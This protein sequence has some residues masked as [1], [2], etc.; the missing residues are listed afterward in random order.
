MMLLRPSP[1][2]NESL[3]GYL[4]RVADNNGLPGVRFVFDLVD[5]VTP[6]EEFGG[7]LGGGGRPLAVLCDLPGV[8]PKADG[9]CGG[10]HNSACL[11]T[12]FWNTR[13]PRFCP[14]C[15]EEFNVWQV[16]WELALVVACPRHNLVLVE[17]CSKCQQLIRWN[18]KHFLECDCG[19]SLAAI[20]AMSCTS[21]ESWISATQA[22]LL[23]PKIFEN[24]R[25]ESELGALSLNDLSLLLMYLGGYASGIST[26][27]LKIAGLYRQ[28]VAQRLVRAALSILAN[29]PENFHS[30]LYELGNFDEDAR[31]ADG[32]MKRFG[33]FYRSLYN[34]L[35]GEQFGFLREAFE[36]FLRIYWP[37]TFARRNRRLSEK[38]VHDHR[39]VPLPAAAKELHISRKTL[40]QLVT[41]GQ[42]TATTHTT[43]RGRHVVCIE[44]N[45][46][47]ELQA[48]RADWITF[49][50]ARTMLGLSKKRFRNLL[51]AGTVPALAGPKIDGSAVWR[52][53]KTLIKS[54]DRKPSRNMN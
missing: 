17:H 27:P 12:R 37:G 8:V 2:A 4:F 24:P 54:L 1:Y 43:L 32:L 30:Y 6:E 19:Q 34:D 15:L 41:S 11:P 49:A 28:A 50:E 39:M 42:L 45:S 9:S 25:K 18:R 52:F 22:H 16:P 36:A 53:S 33:S 31:S 7:R 5:N 46:L 40:L 13:Y 26:K 10:L 3:R 23:M 51:E 21:G 48:R 47:E 38:L 20:A 14:A 29:W 35:Q 44:R